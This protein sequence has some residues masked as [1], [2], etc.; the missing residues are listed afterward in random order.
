MICR[1]GIIADPSQPTHTAN[2][3]GWSAGFL[4]GSADGCSSLPWIPGIFRHR[5]YLPRMVLT[6]RQTTSLASKGAHTWCSPA[7]S[8]WVVPCRR[9]S[10]VV[11]AGTDTSSSTVLSDS[12]Q[13]TEISP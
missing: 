5:T 6:F 2:A 9:R 10:A 1:S 3:L 8:V 11:E 7:C 4:L 13:D 12:C